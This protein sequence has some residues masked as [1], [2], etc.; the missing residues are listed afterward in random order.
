M[1]R[2]LAL[3]LS[4]GVSR[5]AQTPRA[6]SAARALGESRSGPSSV[7][8]PGQGCTIGASQLERGAD[9]VRMQA[10]EPQSDEASY[11]QFVK[12]LKAELGNTHPDTVTAQMNLAILLKR[13]TDNVAE[14]RNIHE[15]VVRIRTE[16]LGMAHADTL[17]AKVRAHDTAGS[18]AFHCPWFD[19][20]LTLYPARA[21]VC[22]FVCRHVSH[23]LVDE[24]RKSARLY[25]G[26]RRSRISS[27]ADDGGIV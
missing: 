21:R 11:R 7:Q 17:V 25:R 3:Q 10:E 8:L 16:Q 24:P 2:R 20:R 13:T 9:Y 6:Q 12:R 23:M 19:T 5:A 27:Q 26:F 18:V 22:V 15:E 14:A 4:G 1:R